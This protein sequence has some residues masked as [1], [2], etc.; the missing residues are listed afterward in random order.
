MSKT[1]IL[2]DTYKNCY[3]LNIDFN[4]VLS[5]TLTCYKPDENGRSCG[6]CGSCTERLESFNELELQ[7]PVSYME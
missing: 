2:K 3:N 5:N 1:E 6:K 4:T 7:D